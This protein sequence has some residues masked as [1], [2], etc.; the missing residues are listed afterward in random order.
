MTQQERI[1][2]IK[3]LYKVLGSLVLTEQQYKEIEDKIYKLAK[4][5]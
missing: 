3:I 4:G 2:T 5:L 1:N